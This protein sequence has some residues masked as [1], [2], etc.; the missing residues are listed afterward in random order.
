MTQSRPFLGLLTAAGLALLWSPDAAAGSADAPAARAEAR[1]AAAAELARLA[2]RIEALKREAA[3][4]RPTGSELERLLARAQELAR[5]LDELDRLDRDPAPSPASR[6]APPDSQELR[7]RADALRD[8]ADRLATA[9]AEVDRRLFAARRRAELAER[10]EAVGGPGDLFAESAPRRSLAAPPSATAHEPTGPG[11]PQIGNLPSAAPPSPPGAGV[12]TAP[13]A[14]DAAALAPG[15][16][17]SVSG[18]R[19]RRAEI[20]AALA[21]LRARAEALEAEA[22]D[23]EATR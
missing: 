5:L 19:R 6:P 21:A 12:I 16:D 8:R 11:A 9:L 7:E 14:R 18:L 22:K 13:G 1:G 15:A 10:L 23:A 20:A 17:E 3:A 2:P 4:G